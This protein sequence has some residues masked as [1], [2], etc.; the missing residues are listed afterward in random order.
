MATLSPHS[1]YS[2]IMSQMAF[3][4][5]DISNMEIKEIL[6]THQF[7][8]NH[9]TP[10]SGGRTQLVQIPNITKHKQT[11]THTRVRIYGDIHINICMYVFMY[12]TSSQL[13]LW[14]TKEGKWKNHHHVVCTS[15]IAIGKSFI[16]VLYLRDIRRTKNQPTDE[17]FPTK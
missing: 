17:N 2:F 16:K 12:M 3:H 1:L 5:V 9:R 14:R 8:F 13:L 11:N 7:S 10:H 6:L 4:C 15:T